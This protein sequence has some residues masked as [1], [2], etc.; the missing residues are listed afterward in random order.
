[1][2][3]PLLSSDQYSAIFTTKCIAIFS[4]TPYEW[5]TQI[6]ATMLRSIDT[7]DVAIGGGKSLLFSTLAACLGKSTLCITPLQ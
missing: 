7:S 3:D 5:Q 4:K 6:G 1:M 2:A